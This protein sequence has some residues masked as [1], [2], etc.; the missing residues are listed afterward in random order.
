[1]SKE[2]KLSQ[3]MHQSNTGKQTIRNVDLMKV[4]EDFY[5]SIGHGPDTSLKN[6]G[7]GQNPSV[8]SRAKQMERGKNMVPREE[9][10][11]AVTP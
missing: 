9:G 8:Q 3:I 11:G 6:E 7:K 5:K 2:H 1:M 10:E 4:S